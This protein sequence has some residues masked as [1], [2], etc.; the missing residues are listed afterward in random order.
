MPQFLWS[1][2]NSQTVEADHVAQEALHRALSAEPTGIAAYKQIGELHMK[3]QQ[4]DRRGLELEKELQKHRSESSSFYS[5]HS[6]VSR[7]WEKEKMEACVS[8]H[9]VQTTIEEC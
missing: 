6:D 3:L 8:D 2:L 9:F 7:S 4:A 1:A 5:Q